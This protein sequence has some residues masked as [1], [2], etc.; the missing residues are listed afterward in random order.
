[1]QPRAKNPARRAMD[2][3]Y[4]EARFKPRGRLVADFTV[5]ADGSVADP[6]VTGSTTDPTDY[7]NAR[8]LASLLKWRFAPVSAPCRH[9]LAFSFK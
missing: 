6:L 7:Y 1:M 8:V 4:R 2:D 3:D 9:Q 5:L